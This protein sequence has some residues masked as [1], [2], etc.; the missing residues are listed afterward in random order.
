MVSV[1]LYFFRNHEWR[2]I[3]TSQHRVGFVVANDGF[4]FTVEFYLTADYVID[5]LKL[6]AIFLEMVLHFFEVFV[7]LFVVAENLV[8]FAETLF[9]SQL[10]GDVCEVAESARYM[11]LQNMRVHVGGLA[12]ADGLDEV[13]EV[14]SIASVG[15]RAFH[16][17]QLEH[18]LFAYLGVLVEILFVGDAHVALAAESSYVEHKKAL[19]IVENS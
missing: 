2:A 13:G 17:F 5:F 1:P 16:A 19:S 9:F 10:V 8:L 6:E 7:S 11:T 15:G 4:F 14:V 3:V 12:T 18:F